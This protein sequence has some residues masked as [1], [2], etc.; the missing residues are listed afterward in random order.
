[1]TVLNFIPGMHDNCQTSKNVDVHH[2]AHSGGGKKLTTV[3]FVSENVDNFGWPLR[4]H[5]FISSVT[6]FNLINN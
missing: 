5:L 3:L 6:K 1:M 4:F 2:N